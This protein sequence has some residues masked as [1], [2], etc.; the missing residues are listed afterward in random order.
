MGAGSVMPASSIAYGEREPEAILAVAEALVRNGG[1]R[2]ITPRPSSGD[3]SCISSLAETLTS[4][5]YR[6]R[7]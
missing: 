7:A 4:R 2:E 5:F 6:V 1:Y 3:Y